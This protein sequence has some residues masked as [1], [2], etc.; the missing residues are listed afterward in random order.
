VCFLL[1]SSADDSL[2]HHAYEPV[3]WVAHQLVVVGSAIQDEWFL[4]MGYL[5]EGFAHYYRGFWP[6]AWASWNSALKRLSQARAQRANDQIDLDFL[7][8]RA[9]D[10]REFRAKIGDFAWFSELLERGDVSE[11]RAVMRV[12]V[13][14]CPINEHKWEQ[15]RADGRQYVAHC[16][17]CKICGAGDI[18]ELKSKPNGEIVA[19]LTFVPAWYSDAMARRELVLWCMGK[20]ERTIKEMQ[21]KG[22]RVIRGKVTI[23]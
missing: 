3:E 12:F 11:P 19:D 7:N 18:L 15:R 14:E 8:E 9:N 5:F 2:D 1:I 4:T 13:T 16:T 23:P 10:A 22:G 17:I 21:Q 20:Y 6:R